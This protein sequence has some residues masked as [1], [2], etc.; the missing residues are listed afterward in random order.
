MWVWIPPKVG[1]VP[2]SPPGRGGKP[3]RAA[4]DWLTGMGQLLQSAC[5]RRRGLSLVV[6]GCCARRVWAM[7]VAAHAADAVTVALSFFARAV[8]CPVELRAQLDVCLCVTWACIVG[9]VPEFVRARAASAAVAC[10]RAVCAASCGPS[11]PLQEHMIHTS[12][13][14]FVVCAGCNV[15]WRLCVGVFLVRPVERRPR[16]AASFEG[17]SGL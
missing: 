9:A 15:A 2:L 12:M 16:L 7:S 14:C 11:G 17:L 3:R 5:V 13:H 6:C 1:W 4:A 8:V 10:C